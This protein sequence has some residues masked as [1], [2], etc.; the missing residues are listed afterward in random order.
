MAFFKFRFSGQTPSAE[1]V[2]TGPSESI[3][4]VRRRARHRLTGAVVLVL[5]AV[6]GFPLLFDTQPRPVSVDTPIVVPDRQKTPALASNLP[7]PAAQAPA[8]PLLP[9]TEAATVPAHASLD[10]REEVV[11]KPAASLVDK[12]ADNPVEKPVITKAEAKP[13]AKPESRPEAKAP[14][15]P[16]PKDDGQKAQA[17]LE[18]KPVKPAASKVAIQV[19]AFTDAAKIRDVRSKLEQAGLKTYT[20]VVEKDGKS[21]TRIRVGPFETKEEADKA[22]AR[23]R[24]LDL[25][26]AVLK[27]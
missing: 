12:P 20:Q 21:T 5:L 10:A 2:A 26:A 4:I 17:L 18:G 27:L 24:K 23:I 8:K 14:T 6:V 16:K 3:E 1:G 25:P 13:E 15:P 7:V 22:A 11:P 9:N 19:G